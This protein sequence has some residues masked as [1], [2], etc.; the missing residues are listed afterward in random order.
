MGDGDDRVVLRDVRVHGDVGIRMGAGDDQVIVGVPALDPM[1]PDP[2]S[3]EGTPPS[4]P[5]VGIG[6]SLRIGMGEGNDRVHVG[7]AAIRGSLDIA[8]DGG[9]DSVVLGHPPNDPPTP[10]VSLDGLRRLSI[11][12]RPAQARSVAHGIHANLGEGND[13]LIADL[14]G[15]AGGL[16]ADGGLGDD[17]LGVHA[18]RIG[19]ALVLLGGEGEGMDHVAVDHVSAHL[20]TIATGAGNDNV[21]IVDSLFFLLGVH[22]G[23]GNDTLAV[24]GNTAHGAILMGG[25]G[26]DTLLGFPNNRF[27]RHIVRGFELPVMTGGGV[28]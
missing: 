18:S 13:G 20:A 17:N 22:L 3:V 8:T 6:G 25:E 16:L 24:E 23:D 26:E 4:P 27:H 15:T 19:R 11:Q 12:S 9:D 10:P 1:P 7:H 28:T 5:P 21:R 14:V 2:A